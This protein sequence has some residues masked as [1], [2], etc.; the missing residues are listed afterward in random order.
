MCFRISISKLKTMSS[1]Q[2]SII[3]KVLRRARMMT[4]PYAQGPTTPGKIR[5]ISHKSQFQRSPQDNPTHN[6][7][8][9]LR[10]TKNKITKMNV[11]MP[12]LQRVQIKG[13]TKK[14]LDTQKKIQD[15][16]NIRRAKLRY[17]YERRK[18]Y[19]K[20]EEIISEYR[21]TKLDYKKNQTQPTSINILMDGRPGKRVVEAIL[22]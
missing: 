2:T 13:L 9:I 12:L 16:K 14:A 8:D 6:V 22:Q 11:R 18:S 5:Q 10:I 15:M 4:N 7:N 1:S 17:L 19:D 3:Q 20:A 21:S